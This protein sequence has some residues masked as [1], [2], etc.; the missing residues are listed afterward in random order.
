MKPEISQE[1]YNKIMD[2]FYQSM[3]KLEVEEAAWN[4]RILKAIKSIKGE[5]FLKNLLELAEESE[6]CGKFDIVKVPKGDYQ[7][8]DWG[9]INGLWVDQYRNGGCTGDEF[10]GNIYVELKKGKYLEM[11]YSM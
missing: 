7:E 1:E 3:K 4:N 6:V 9:T 5:E 11:N 10:A 2:D 8:E